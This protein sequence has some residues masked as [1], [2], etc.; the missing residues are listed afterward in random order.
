MK[1][2]IIFT[3]YLIILFDILK[4]SL[5]SIIYKNKEVVLNENCKEESFGKILTTECILI[6]Q[7]KIMIPNQ[8]NDGQCY[9]TPTECINDTI[10]P[11][12]P[13]QSTT[14]AYL[15]DLRKGGIFFST[16]LKLKLC[17]EG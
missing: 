7:R 4:L 10:E 1:K 8:R 12:S 11:K 15:P 3:T 2:L 14:V 5:G 9:C 6:C 13:S 17:F 16:D